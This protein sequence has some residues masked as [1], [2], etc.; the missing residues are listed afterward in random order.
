MKLHELI[1]ADVANLP[2][3]TLLI[4]TRGLRSGGLV[5][6]TGFSY[7][8]AEAV[9]SDNH[10]DHLTIDLN[11]EVEVVEDD[12]TDFQRSLE[13]LKDQLK[14][15]AHFIE[16]NRTG[17]SLPEAMLDL[18]GRIRN[19]TD[20]VCMSQPGGVIKLIR[21]ARAERLAKI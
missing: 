6:V 5:I 8:G 7:T 21:I 10:T 13:E 16:S 12:L 18:L 4:Q 17:E 9:R 2:G 1:K 14:Y 11:D 15:M 3:A 19:T 20:S